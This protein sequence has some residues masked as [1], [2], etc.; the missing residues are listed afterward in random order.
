M[1]EKN[2]NAIYSPI[3]QFK[4]FIAIE[5]GLS[6]NTSN[7][8][9]GDLEDFAEY[10]CESGFTQYSDIEREDIEDYLFKCKERGLEASTMARRLVC[11]KVF[12]SYLFQDRIIPVNILEVQAPEVCR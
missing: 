8:Y 6:E 9:L 7:A 11:L 4:G 12:F 10:L 1:D 2:N 5:R 3:R